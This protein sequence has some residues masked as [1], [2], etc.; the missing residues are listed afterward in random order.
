[1]I[2]GLTV[3]AVITAR[4][5]S[6]RVPGKNLRIAGGKPLL[7]WTLEA[8]RQATLLDRV[9]LSTDSL[10]IAEM[11]ARMGCEVP[12]LRPAELARDDTPGVAPVLHALDTLPETY[13]LV[14]L[15][16]PTTP[17][18]V[19]ADVDGCIR[20]CV[21]TG[22]AACVSVCE[23]AQSPHWMYAMDAQGRLVPFLAEEPSRKPSAGYVLNGA[24]Y[25]ARPEWLKAQGS[26]HHEA[27]RGYVMPV[28]RSL[29]VDSEWDL[30]L[31]DHLL[32]AERT[33]RPGDSA[34]EP[35]SAPIFLNGDKK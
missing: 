10:E 6:R 3:L 19:G 31:C 1:M 22:A 24:V 25:V 23:L 7:A 35:E 30:R 13:D 15:L 4:G 8:A 16:Q 32:W 20:H 26:F 29:D 28:E 14:V 27:T 12:F 11:G 17:L 2:A 21:E 9:I 5:G 33:R 18:R 34:G